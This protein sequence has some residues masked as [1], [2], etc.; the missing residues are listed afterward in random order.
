MCC[1]YFKTWFYY[2]GH[3]FWST[4]HVCSPFQNNNH[5]NFVRCKRITIPISN[6]YRLKLFYFEMY[7]IYWSW[8]GYDGLVHSDSHWQWQ[9][10]AT[11]GGRASNEQQILTSTMKLH[12]F[13]F[14]F[15]LVWTCI[16]FLLWV[17]L[18]NIISSSRN[19]QKT[20]S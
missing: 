15:F 9:Q 2:L 7:Q 14:L 12:P 5:T 16:H 8:C 6:K 11:L 13:F 4:Q 18:M 19:R 20:W 1:Y 17:T 10:A 3:A